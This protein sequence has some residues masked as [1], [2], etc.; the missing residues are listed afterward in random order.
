MYLISGKNIARSIETSLRSTIEKLG[1]RPHLVVFLIGEHAPS[2]T[3]VA[4]KRAACARV[5]IQST[6]YE[7]PSSISQCS[8]LERI[9]TANQEKKTHAILVQMPLPPH[10]CAQA[11]QSAI[12]P[13]K[14]VD[15][16]H[17]LI[18][19]KTLLGQ[20]GGIYPCTPLGICTLLETLPVSFAEKEAVIVGRSSIVGKPLA[21]MLLAKTGVAPSSV[22]ITHSKTP[23]RKRNGERRSNRNRCRHLPR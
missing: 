7:L 10:I 3:Y 14:D 6:V 19:G 9:Q 16:F 2:I 17:P 20:T 13:E 11:V 1:T 23:D 22:T 12:V 8:L 18:M 4:N 15:G 21:A 5:G